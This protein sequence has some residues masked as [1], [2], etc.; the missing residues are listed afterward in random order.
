[1]VEPY[2]ARGR[3]VMASDVFLP[4][5]IGAACPFFEVDKI[6]GQSTGAFPEVMSA[7]ISAAKIRRVLGRRDGR[8]V[9]RGAQ[10]W[11]D[12][13]P[14]GDLGGAVSVRTSVRWSATLVRSRDSPVRR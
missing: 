13:H 11:T 10:R 3:L 6:G 12:S 2:E 7:K 8:L 14:L 9:V 4:G 5:G 1:M